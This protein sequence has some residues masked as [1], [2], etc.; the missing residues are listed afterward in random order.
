[1][2]RLKELLI[3]EDTSFLDEKLSSGTLELTF[4]KMMYILIGG[5]ISYKLIDSHK[6]PDIIIGVIVVS[7]ALALAFY[8]PKSQRLETIFLGAISY[9][10]GGFFTP[11]PD[12]KKIDKKDNKKKK[13]VHIVVETHKGVSQI[14][15]IEKIQDVEIA[16]ELDEGEEGKSRGKSKEKRGKSKKFDYAILGI[17]GASSLM[18]FK[19]LLHL[20]AFPAYH[21]I[22]FTIDILLF[23]V[24]VAVFISEII[25]I[26]S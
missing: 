8:P 14:E 4:R 15:K 18:L 17:S 9:F 26:K 21:L 24:S 6:F 12:I 10:L 16:N 2:V 11:D 5:L 3:L 20:L 1:M 13:K 7:I 25:I 23:S 19:F 22:D